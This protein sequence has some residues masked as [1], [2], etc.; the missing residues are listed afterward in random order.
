MLAG[1][2]IY[3][4]TLLTCSFYPWLPVFLTPMRVD[5][6]KKEQIEQGLFGQVLGTLRLGVFCPS[7]FS[8]L[9]CSLFNG[10]AQTNIWMIER[11]TPIAVLVV[12][13]KDTLLFVGRRIFRKKRNNRL[14]H[15][16]QDSNRMLNWKK[17][18]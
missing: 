9:G 1:F 10:C 7:I 16:Q 8:M 5:G 12:F 15:A 4:G 11:Y 14:D 2:A 6:L 3:T 17:A 13:V 18:A